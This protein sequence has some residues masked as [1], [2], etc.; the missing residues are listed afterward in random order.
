MKG[1]VKWWHEQKGFGMINAEDGAEI[2]VHFTSIDHPGWP[3]LEQ[4]ETVFFR[5]V[6]GPKGPQAFQVIRDKYP[7]PWLRHQFG[8]SDL[9]TG[10]PLRLFMCHSSGDKQTVRQ[11]TVRLQHDGVDA[12]IDD[13]KLLP[14]QDWKHEISQSLR[15]SDAV[16]V[17]LSRSSIT[18]AGFVQRELKEALDLS[19]EQPDGTIFLIPL[20]LESCDVP[21]RLR[22]W[23]WVDYYEPDG[24]DKLRNAL[25]LRSDQ[26]GIGA[27]ST[28]KTE[29]ERP[30]K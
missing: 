9:E 25:R 10:R 2:F 18:K 29:R 23:Q 14:G 11:L 6:E 21:E 27:V 16:L 7:R 22:R 26:L 17:C 12:W 15:R 13:D 8:V 28:I 20:R 4:G 30:W 19:D 5:T 24:Y 1:V 3:S